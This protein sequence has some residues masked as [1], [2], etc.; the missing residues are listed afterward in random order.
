MLNLPT[1]V[2]V[3]FNDGFSAIRQKAGLLNGVCRSKA[4]A[5]RKVCHVNDESN[6][7]DWKKISWQTIGKQL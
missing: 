7:S 6:I 2:E 3:R 5:E 4:A 1:G